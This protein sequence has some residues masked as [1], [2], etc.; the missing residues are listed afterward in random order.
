MLFLNLLTVLLGFSL[1]LEHKL[2]DLFFVCIIHQ[3]VILSYPLMFISFQCGGGKKFVL[4][5]LFKVITFKVFNHWLSV[6]GIL[7]YLFVITF[8]A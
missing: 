7:L 8:F 1:L 3:I 2:G 4:F 5:N 6:F